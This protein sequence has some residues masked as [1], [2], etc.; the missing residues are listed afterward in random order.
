MNFQKTINEMGAYYE[1]LK[2]EKQRTMNG[3][4]TQTRPE[5]QTSN[6]AK[7]K[8]NFLGMTYQR[9][10]YP[11]NNANIINNHNVAEKPKQSEREYLYMHQDPN[12]S[13]QVHNQ[14]NHFNAYLDN[15]IKPANLSSSRGI[16]LDKFLSSR[17]PYQQRQHFEKFDDNLPA[18]YENSDLDQSSSAFVEY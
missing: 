6:I 12:E 4:Y 11:E 17:V 13:M 3:F 2:Y 5:A 9:T 10:F 16:E 14:G 18:N 1:N 8:A 7:T 15:F